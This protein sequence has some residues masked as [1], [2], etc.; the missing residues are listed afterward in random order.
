MVLNAFLT[1]LIADFRPVAAAVLKERQ[2][3]IKVPFDKSF[4]WRTNTDIGDVPHVAVAII[5]IGPV[6]RRPRRMGA[7]A[8]NVRPTSIWPGWVIKILADAG[9]KR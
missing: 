6:P 8:R 4:Y 2:L 3:V 7:S 9:L 1:F 5:L